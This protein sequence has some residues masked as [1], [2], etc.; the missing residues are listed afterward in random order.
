VVYQLRD[1][2]YILLVTIYSKSDETTLAASE[3]RKI[4]DRFNK[5]PETPDQEI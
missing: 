1:T 2:T 5:P 3:I 4:I